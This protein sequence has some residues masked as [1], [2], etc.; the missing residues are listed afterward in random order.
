MKAANRPRIVSIRVRPRNVYAERG[1]KIEITGVNEMEALQGNLKMEVAAGDGSV[2]FTKTVKADV[3][4]GITQLFSESLDTKALA[5]TYTLKATITADD[6]SPIAANVYSFDVFTAEQPAVAK[7]R[8]AVLDP[9]NS[10]KPFLRRAG[11]AFVEFDAKTDRSSPVF[12]SRTVANTPAPS[13]TTGSPITTSANATT[14][15]R[16][17]RGGAAMWPSLRRARDAV[18]SRNFVWSK[19]S[20]A[21]PWPTRSC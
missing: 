9:S 14:M 19:T 15:G 1:T 21:I 10:L 13:A 20:A 17:T 18:S 4:S 16:V 6:G 5:G 8:I 2:A 11:I 7:K 12:V 3:A